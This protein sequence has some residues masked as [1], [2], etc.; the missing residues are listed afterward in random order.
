V[1]GGWSGNETPVSD[2]DL[3]REEPDPEE[4]AVLPASEVMSLL[5]TQDAPQAEEDTT[6]EDRS[7]H[8]ERSDSA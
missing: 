7:E 5:G 2:R 1:S 6:P 4:P 3:D 8:V